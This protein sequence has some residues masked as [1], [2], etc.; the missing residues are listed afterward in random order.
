ML[1]TSRKEKLHY[2][3]KPWTRRQPPLNPIHLTDTSATDLPVSFDVTK[4]MSLHTANSF[5]NKG[6]VLQRRVE[7]QHF[8]AK[9]PGI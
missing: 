6:R 1:S 5:F 9:Y 7:P 3:R 4:S 8:P 2:D